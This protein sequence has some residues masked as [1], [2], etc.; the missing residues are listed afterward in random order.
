MKG[1]VTKL[2]GGKYTVLDLNTKES[3]VCIARGKLRYTKLEKESSFNI[4]NTNKTKVESKTIKLSP[5]VGDIVD[6][7]LGETNYIDAI[8]DRKNSLIRPDLANIDQLFLVNSAKEPDFNYSLIDRFLVNTERN[9][10]KTIIVVSKIDLL[11]K[12]EMIKLKNNLKY[13]EKFYDVIFTS[14]KDLIQINEITSRLKD[15]I[16]V[17]SGQT[18]AGKSSLLNSIDDSLNLETQE[19]SKSLNRGKHTT[20]CTSLYSLY[21]GFIAD[22]PGFSSIDFGNIELSEIANCF[23]DF[24][25]FSQECKFRDCKHI[26]EIGCAI[27]KKVESKEILKS[28]YDSY[29]KIYEEVKNTQK[30]Y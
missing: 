26:N 22:T 4:S 11:N 18:G 8:N 21:D 7:V 28:R 1:L 3:F 17:F 2:I 19:I 15:K 23:I 12:D 10:I 9:S 30:K 27:K 6:F 13:Y 14:S 29:Q 16:S 25:A 5:K 20:R 24:K